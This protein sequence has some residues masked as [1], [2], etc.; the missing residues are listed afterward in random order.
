M[1]ARNMRLP[2]WTWAAMITV[3]ALGFVTGRSWDALSKLGG[4]GYSDDKR[5][6]T[7]GS[8]AKSPYEYTEEAR[9]V[10]LRIEQ[11]KAIVAGCTK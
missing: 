9:K 8:T 11:A 1:A 10:C 7:F 5:P 2:W 4:G 6:V 3:G